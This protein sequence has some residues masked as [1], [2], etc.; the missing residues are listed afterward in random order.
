MRSLRTLAD[1]WRADDLAVS[2]V[3]LRAGVPDYNALVTDAV[4][5]DEALTVFRRLD[6]RRRLGCTRDRDRLRA[7]MARLGAALGRFHN[8]NSRATVFRMD[9]SI[10]KI[11]QYCREIASGTRSPVLTDVSRALQ[12]M[13]GQD[14][15]AVEVTTLKGIDIRNVLM[16]DQDRLFLLDPGRLKRACREADLARFIMTYR[17]LY[18]GSRLFLLGLRPDARAERAFLE[19]YYANSAPPSPKL[20][21]FFLM[22]E[23]IKHWHTALDSLRLRPWPPALKRLV[24][25][26]YVNPFYTRQLTEELAQVI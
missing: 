2:W 11:E 14:I 16:D 15:G 24:A 8:V 12:E 5:G 3:R 23:Q 22:K 6:L 21:G 7:A 26:I 1:Q 25:A 20:L 17:I 4:Q 13:A 10:S 18:W 9:R 19:A